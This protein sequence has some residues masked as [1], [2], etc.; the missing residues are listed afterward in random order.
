M[1]IFT[2]I[3]QKKTAKM[4]I[5]LFGGCIF[6][7]LL[8]ALIAAAIRSGESEGEAIRNTIAM[9]EKIELEDALAA[10][11]TI[12]YPN[13][14]LPGDILPALRLHFYTATTLDQLLVS[15]FGEEYALIDADV[16]RYIN[17]TLEE[18]ESAVR[19]G[20]STDLGV[21]N[22]GVYMLILRNDLALR[23]S[24]EG[25]LLPAG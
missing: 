3:R 16:L 6:A 17:L 2:G 7:M 9:Q 19:Q 25:V 5:L 23:F 8:V 15:S 11:D 22:L 21:E 10:F 24:S 13:A 4:Y 14:D 20:N 18:L 1:R 12:G